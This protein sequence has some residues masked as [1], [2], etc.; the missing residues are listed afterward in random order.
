MAM[1]TNQLQDE[2]DVFAVHNGE[3][4]METDQTDSQR[5][6]CARTVQ[7]EIAVGLAVTKPDMGDAPRQQPAVLRAG[8]I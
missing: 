8:G 6:I 1:F 7:E 2:C 4:Q 3:H 5:H